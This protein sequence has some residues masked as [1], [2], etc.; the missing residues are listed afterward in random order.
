MIL[1][2]SAQVTPNFLIGVGRK[3][4]VEEDEFDYNITFPVDA[5]YT[6]LVMTTDLM[7]KNFKVQVGGDTTKEWNI[8]ILY[9]RYSLSARGK[10]GVLND[11]G[12]NVEFKP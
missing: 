2:C 7:S 11:F 8:D 5:L 4:G 3:K 9:N 12:F 1:D 10:K 6:Y